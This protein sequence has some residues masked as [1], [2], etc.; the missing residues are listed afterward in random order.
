MNQLL[1]HGWNAMVAVSP[2]PAAPARW[3][4]F[5]LFHNSSSPRRP[6]VHRPLSHPNPRVQKG[7]AGA[8]L[9]LLLQRR[10][11]LRRRR[12]GRKLEVGGV[13]VLARVRAPEELVLLQRPLPRVALRLVLLW[14]GGG[15]G[16]WIG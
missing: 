14:V 12:A 6:A 13:D 1:A 10:L 9:G 7:P 15:G 2:P 8:P 4:G 5:L 11:L 16:E 3:L